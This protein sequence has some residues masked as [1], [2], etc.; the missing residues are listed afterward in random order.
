RSRPQRA[1]TRAGRTH[2]P[3]AS[4]HLIEDTAQVALVDVADEPVA[5]HPVAVNDERRRHPEQCEVVHERAGGILR[6]GVR[7]AELPDERSSC[8]IVV[9]LIDADEAHTSVAVVDPHALEP[10]ASIAHGPHHEPQKFKTVM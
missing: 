5:E 7:E 3:T 4:K 2:S 9:E 10:G 8:G 6:T 1:P